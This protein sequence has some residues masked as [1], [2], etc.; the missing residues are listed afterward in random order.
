MKKLLKDWQVLIFLAGVIISLLIISPSPEKAVIVKSVSPDSPLAGKLFP[1]EKLEWINERE[2]KT[3]DDVMPFEE[4]TGTLRFIHNGKLDLADITEP[5]LGITLEQ[6]SFSNINFG[7]DIIGGTRVL[8]E[9]K[10][11]VS[12][13]TIQRSIATLQT[14]INIYGLREA[15]FQPVYDIVSGKNYIQIEMAGGSR[16]EIDSLLSRQGK[17]EA[18]IPKIIYLANGEG[19]L[20]N[21]TFRVSN[22]SIVLDGKTYN[23]NDTF[24]LNDIEWEVSNVSSEAV[25]LTATVLTGSDIKAV[26]ITEQAGICASRVQR[27]PGGYRFIFQITVSDEGAKRFADVTAGMKQIVEPATGE[28]YLES[29]IYFFIDD[30]PITEL[31]IGAELAGRTLTDP[32]IN[33]FR[34]TYQEAVHEKLALQS[35]L[36]SGS[37]PVGFEIKRVD[38]ISPTLGAGF[39]KSALLA[40]LIAAT[41]VGTVVFIRYRRIKICVPIIVTA[42]SE[43][44]MILGVA[45]LIR[46]TID[47]SAI[48]AI[49]AT[50]GTGVDAQLMIIDEILMGAQ[51]K[52]YTA[53]QRLK[54]AFFMIFGA[55]A[56]V[57]AAMLPLGIIGIGI[58]RG[59]AIVTV[60]GVL[61][62]I[63]ITRPAFGK[64]AEYILQKE[65]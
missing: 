25:V 60:I 10:E 43:V 1:G 35:I 24:E 6:R 56:T 2:I 3:P 33:G 22:N 32:S 28:S 52:I 30:K 4:F 65:I 18:K 29:K 26:C 5:G 54:R 23:L 21:H 50:V 41:A 49:I 55:A 63:F 37:L 8:L 44:I 51:Q 39:L 46:W 34:K 47:L 16:Q 36:Q 61:I 13:D 17:F 59:F 7:L 31:N 38:Q 14:R 53:K 40:G 42:L 57:I 12:S 20:L 48:A 15:R 45:A 11:N 58:M 27:V 64:I 9:P 19:E 62:G